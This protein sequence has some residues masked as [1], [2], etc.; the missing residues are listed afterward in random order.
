MNKRV[1]Q[2]CSEFDERVNAV[3][4]GM[5]RRWWARRLA[6]LEGENAHLYEERDHLRSLLNKTALNAV[7]PDNC[8]EL[9]FIREC[10]YELILA[11]ENKYPG[12]DRHQTALRFIRE[13]QRPLLQALKA[14]GGG[15]CTC[16]DNQGGPCASCM[17][18]KYN[19]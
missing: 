3:G 13:S 12:E 6:E 17:E 1:E 14:D 8:E 2:L 4:V 15:K 11:V 5:A 18:T 7:K 19:L 10:Y 16:A 9:E